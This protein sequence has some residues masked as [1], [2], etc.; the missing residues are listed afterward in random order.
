MNAAMQIEMIAPVS[1]AS[2]ALPRLGLGILAALTPREDEIIYTDEVIEPFDLERD[3]KDVGLVAIS[4]D[5]KTARRSYDIAAA[6]RRRGVPVVLGGIHP[7]ACPEEAMAHADAIVVGEADEI[8]PTVVAD[9]KRREFKL[10]F[11]RVV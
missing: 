3:L 2:A 8:W 7:T 6:Y 5:S 10:F 9:A 4:V 1:T 11:M